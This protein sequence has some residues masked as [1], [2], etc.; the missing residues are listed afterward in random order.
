MTTRSPT[1]VGLL[2]GVTARRMVT[3]ADVR[4]ALGAE[5]TL[6]KTFGS[7]SVN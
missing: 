3:R 7:I 1:P 6:V 2:R 5:R 4:R